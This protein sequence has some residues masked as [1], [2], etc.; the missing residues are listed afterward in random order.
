[1]HASLVRVA[2]TPTEP[3]N[4]AMTFEEDLALMGFRPG[5]R[6]RDGS[7]PFSLARNRFLTY[8]VHVSP[9]EDAP[10]LFTWEFAI[11][12]YVREYGFQIGADEPLNQFLYPAA[13]E[14]LTPDLGDVVAAM[15]RIEATFQQMNFGARSI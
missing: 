3:D 13:D 15:E 10:V 6:K 5:Q 7:L 8:G 14:T 12:E 4:A 11:G 2:P 1:M 9:G